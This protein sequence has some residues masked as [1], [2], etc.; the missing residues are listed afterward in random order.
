MVGEYNPIFEK[1]FKR[2][3]QDGD[4]IIAYI[5]YGLY[6]ERKRNFLISRQAQLAGPVPPEE[7]ATFHR[8][9]E[10]EGQIN[11]VWDAAKDALAAFAVNYADAEKAAAVKA[12]LKEAVKGR[13][14]RLVWTTTAA[15]FLFAIG[16]ILLYLL[17]R[18]V[19]FDPLDIFRKLDQIIP[20]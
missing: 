3:Q 15:N 17:L 8:I 16:A 9:Y 20:K 7:I 14:W 11:L 10:D 6:K 5:A 4:E 13:F 1:I 18:L 19:G 2:V 12:A